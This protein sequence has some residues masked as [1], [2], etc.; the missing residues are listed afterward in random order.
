MVDDDMIL[1]E[2]KEYNNLQRGK[3][4]RHKRIEDSVKKN[5]AMFRRR[6]YVNT[7]QTHGYPNKH[8]SSDGESGFEAWR[9]A[10]NYDGKSIQHTGIYLQQPKNSNTQKLHKRVSH[11]KVRRYHGDLNNGRHEQK[12]YDYKW[13]ID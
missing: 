10:W 7:W 9:E 1:E 2:Q 8:R 13:M 12:L 4:R 6:K 11:K 5:D 3:Q